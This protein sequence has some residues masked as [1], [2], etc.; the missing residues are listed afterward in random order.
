MARHIKWVSVTRG[1]P[2][3]PKKAAPPKKNTAPPT[4][5][6]AKAKPG[7]HNCFDRYNVNGDERTCAH[8]GCGK[9]I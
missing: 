7:A 8:P 6:K 2:T 3:A 9:R 1:E 4:T 5:E